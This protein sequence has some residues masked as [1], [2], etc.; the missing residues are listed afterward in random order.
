MDNAQKGDNKAAT[1]N[2]DAAAALLAGKFPDLGDHTV[3]DAQEGI[4][5]FHIV[6]GPA[7]GAV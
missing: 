4:L 6:F 2:R 7:G 1:M 3:L 5:H